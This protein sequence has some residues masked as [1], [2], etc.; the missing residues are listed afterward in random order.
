[1][2]ARVA[3]LAALGMTK[4]ARARTCFSVSVAVTGPLGYFFSAAVMGWSS[5]CEAG[6]GLAI[7]KANAIR[8]TE[9]NLLVIP[10]EAQPE[11]QRGHGPPA[12]RAIQSIARCRRNRK[13]RS[14]CC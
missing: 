6:A 4:G 3:L 12:S 10:G 14:P 7:V 9:V 5:F 13:S 11:P 2:N 1:M 8:I